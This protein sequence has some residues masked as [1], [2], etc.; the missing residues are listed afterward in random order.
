MAEYIAP[1]TAFG[2]PTVFSQ[3]TRF[4]SASE[5]TT[6]R[7]RTVVNN[8]YGNYPQSQKA[9]YASTYTTFQAGAVYNDIGEATVSLVPTCTTNT[10]GFIQANNTTIVPTGEKQTP[11]MRVASRAD[12]NNPQ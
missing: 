6:M 11:N 4:K 1:G 5:V 12:M 8:Y 3:Q 10:R 2:S 9:A 7:K